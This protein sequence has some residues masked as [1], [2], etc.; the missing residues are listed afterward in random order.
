MSKIDPDSF[1]DQ[2]ASILLE[3]SHGNQTQ[4]RISP[5]NSTP[6]TLIDQ[7]NSRVSTVEDRLNACDSIYRLAA[8]TNAVRDRERREQIQS[9]GKQAAIIE[10]RMAKIEEKVVSIPQMIQ[11]IVK[12]E[13]SKIDHTQQINSQ[14]DQ[15][16]AHFNDR[17]SAVER[18]FEETTKR[19]QKA[20]K[21]IKIDMQL[22]QTQPA[23]DSRAEELQ[24]QI[25]ELKRRQNMMLELLNA[26]RSHNEQDF[27][28]VNTQLN[29]LWSQ[30]S[31]KR[32][33]Q[34][35]PTRSHLE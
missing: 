28:S 20:I 35:T 12:E 9:L 13:I 34:F 30:L 29:G 26:I 19:T 15:A 33:V 21:K 24:M 17:I 18:S 31:S 16:N 4:T 5:L 25:A 10:Q 32:T 14:I 8:Q 22:A 6:A 11:N 1:F 3:R 23:D 2:Q 27:D 7:I